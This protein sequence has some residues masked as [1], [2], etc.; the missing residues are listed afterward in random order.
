MSARQAATSK[1]TDR[2]E[3]QRNR[4]RRAVVEAASELVRD[5]RVPTVAEAAEAAEV[6]RATAYRYF[7][8]QD[9]LLAEVALW[10]IGGPLDP[11]AE[12]DDEASSV[13]ETMASVV[14]RVARWS[15]DNETALRTLLRL[16]LDPSSGV[17]RPGHRV[18]WIADV[19]AP[20]RDQ[21]DDES[22][23]RLSASL[24]LLFGIDPVVVMT[25][26]AGVSREQA[27]DALAWTARTLVEEA[28]G[29]RE[30]RRRA[31]SSE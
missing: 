18:D 26:I 29:S 17:R 24:T 4:T 23:A 14:R 21:L 30:G 13:A 1:P 28:L 11:L 22:Y 31:P 12:P 7:P 2:R 9:M 27:I 10:A 15:Y 16:S 20:A 6:S 5:G 19:L 25:D 8:T 3:R